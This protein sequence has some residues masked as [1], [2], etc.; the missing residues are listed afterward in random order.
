MSGRG[1]NLYND[2]FKG[3]DVEYIWQPYWTF[4]NTKNRDIDYSY[5][6]QYKNRLVIINFASENWNDFD[7]YVCEQLDKANINF[8]ILTHD[9]LKHQKHPRMF[10]FPHWYEFINADGW[11]EWVDQHPDL[12]LN[13][14]RNYLLGCLNRKPRNHRIINFLKLRKKSYW[15]NICISLCGDELTGRFDDL[16]LL[17]HEIS[18]WSNLQS[19]LPQILWP[20]HLNESANLHLNV[21]QL[22]DS[23]LHLTTEVTVFPMVFMSEK[24]WKPIA[25]AV[26]FVVWGDVGSVA[27]LNSLGVD[28]YNDVIDHQHYDLITDPRTRLDRLHEVID[29][30]MI[31]GVDKIYNQ[32]IDRALENQRKCFNGDFG[33]PYRAAI[34]NAINQYK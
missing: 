32:L 11:K 19:S 5:F 25:A 9:L 23:Y 12:V 15:D 8:L 14:N 18:E 4:A 30:L 3:L 17:D 2:P 1:M 28:T 21:P 7:Y 31:Q 24:I 20:S 16:P 10:Y 33:S 34:I 26:P 22:L 6:E 13:K 29:D 27:A